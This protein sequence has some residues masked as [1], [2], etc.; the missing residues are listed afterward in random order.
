MELGLIWYM[1]SCVTHN[2]FWEQNNQNKQITYI[3]C[4]TALFCI[5]YVY[6]CGFYQYLVIL[7]VLYQFTL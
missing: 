1:D 5:Y 7:N 3:S 4:K 2:T 6:I